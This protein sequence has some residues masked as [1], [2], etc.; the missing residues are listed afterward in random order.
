MGLVPGTVKVGLEPGVTG[1]G[2]ELEFAWNLSLRDEL[3]P[4]FTVAGL[5]WG[6]I[7]AG[8][9]FGTMEVGWS[10]GPWELA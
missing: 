2:L 4:E 6:P 5:V 8:L 10:L 7:R 1:V 9:I 3:G